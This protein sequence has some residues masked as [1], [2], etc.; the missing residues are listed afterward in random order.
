MT[1][2]TSRPTTSGVSASMA[3]HTISVPRPIV[4]V[5][6]WPW[7]IEVVRV[8]R[9]GAQH[10]VRGGVVGIGMHRVRS[11]ERVGRGEADVDDV[12]ATM[13]CGSRARSVGE[14]EDLG[15]VVGDQERVLELR[16]CAVRRR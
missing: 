4:N 6:P 14:R 10:H 13:R 3:V 7:R 15:A 12:D 16:A 2:S 1:S 11:V 9:I 5:R 8:A